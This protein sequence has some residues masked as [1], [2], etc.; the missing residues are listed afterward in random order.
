[1]K[2]AFAAIIVLVLGT[3]AVVGIVAFPLL[4]DKTGGSTEESLE[5]TNQHAWYNQSG[6]SEAAIVVVNTGEADALLRKITIRSI[7]CDWPRVYYWETD[8]GPVSGELRQTT[9]ELSGSA[10]DILI[11]GKQRT[12]QQAN[13]RLG[14]A[15]GSAIVLYIRNPGNITVNDI[16][17]NITITIFSE[18][19]LYY[20]E[21]TVAATFTF[22]KTEELKVQS[23]TWATSRTSISITVKNTGTTTMTISEWRVNDVVVS[24]V[25]YTTGSATLQAGDTAVAR[26]APASGTAFI[27][28]VKY[29]FAAL[30]ATGNKYTYVAT[31]P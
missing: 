21:A 20:K 29:E 12:F 19:K 10:F 16:N 14:L 13:T 6:W 18:N 23:H 3:C 7:E 9:T 30:S 31:A 24:N 26:V 1:M 27:S 17:Q 8:A 5:L 25:T 4:T 11:D 15:S 28:G 22:M 2:T